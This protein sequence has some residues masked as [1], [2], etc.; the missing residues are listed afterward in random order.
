MLPYQFDEI[1][2]QVCGEY[3][4]GIR[5]LFM[6]HA[7]M[8]LL[9]YELG[10]FYLINKPS[11]INLEDYSCCNL[12]KNTPFGFKPLSTHSSVKEINKYAIQ[13]IYEVG[14]KA[15]YIELDNAVIKIGMQFY[16][17]DGQMVTD[18]W[19]CSKENNPA[20]YKEW[21]SEKATASQ[22]E[23]TDFRLI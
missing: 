6:E 1:Y 17:G 15:T 23:I 2:Y 19:F 3:Q 5:I 16:T 7:T 4:N 8:H 13:Q 12:A 11:Q 21:L 22:L 9:V 20:M 14:Q 18:F 10:C